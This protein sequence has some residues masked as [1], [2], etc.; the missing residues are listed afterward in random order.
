MSGMSMLE[1]Q[2]AG[3]MLLC[4]SHLTTFHYLYS[5]VWVERWGI[6]KGNGG[7]DCLI[8]VH[9]TTNM[10]VVSFTGQMDYFQRRGKWRK[11]SV[12]ISQINTTTAISEAANHSLKSTCKCVLQGYYF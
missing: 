3:I 4:S 12:K 8:A 9:A 5:M 6:F 2:N 1:H 7:K 11:Q 10:T